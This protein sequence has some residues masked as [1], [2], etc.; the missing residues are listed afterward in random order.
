MRMFSTILSRV[1]VFSVLLA[2]PHVFAQ[3]V[4]SAAEAPQK[5]EEVRGSTRVAEIRE[6]E[7]GFGFVADA[8]FVYFLGLKGDGVVPMNPEGTQPGARIGARLSFDV[9]H[10]LTVDA[11]LLGVF[12]RNT[13]RPNTA[14]TPEL[15][16]DYTLLTP[17]VGARY[18]F[19]A[20]Q[21][22]FVFA[23][24][25]LGYAMFLPN[26]HIAGKPF[27][28]PRV[29]GSVGVE[30]HTALRHIAIGVEAGADALVFPLAVSVQVVPTIKYTF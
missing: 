10:N 21:R 27:G 6:V 5:G 16:G 1:A 11:H 19:V 4:P 25:A 12:Q 3:G 2:A 28:A 13:I 23:R 20:T 14:E 7:R 29:S 9:L 22:W 17:G 18:A 8:G 26:A 24:G 30:Y 15:W